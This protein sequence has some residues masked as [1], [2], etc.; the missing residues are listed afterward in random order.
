MRRRAVLRV[1]DAYVGFESGVPFPGLRSTEPD[2]SNL[3]SQPVG[4]P[5]GE[6]PYKA[7]IN[8]D[9]V[10]PEDVFKLSISLSFSWAYVEEPSRVIPYGSVAHCTVIRKLASDKPLQAAELLP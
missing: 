5:V 6:P 10:G 8:N 7:L 3:M 2:P 9:K 1:V 4:E